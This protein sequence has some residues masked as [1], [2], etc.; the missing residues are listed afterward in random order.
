MAVF[1]SDNLPGKEGAC[2]T[3]SDALADK[4]CMLY[5]VRGLTRIVW[6]AVDNLPGKD[7]ETSFW[8]LTLHVA[9]QTVFVADNPFGKTV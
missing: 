6:A 1:S 5:A 7:G 8:Q 9:S 2:Q 4:C 3:L